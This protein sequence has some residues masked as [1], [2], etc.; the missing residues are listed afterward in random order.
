MVKLN[1][2]SYIAG[3]WIIPSS[4]V[5]QSKSP[6]TGKAL[7]T[8]NSCGLAEL[9]AAASAAQTAFAEYRVCSHIQISEFLNTI[10]EEIESL[11]DQLLETADAESGLGI[12]RMTGERARTCGQL[13]AFADIVAQGQWV[14]ASIDTAIPDRKPVPKPDLRRMMRPLGPVAVF[15]ASNFPFAY[16]SVGGD[17]ASALAAGNP[18][19][20]KGHPSHPATNELF[21][22][23][24]DAAI[25][26]CNMPRGV[27]SML[28]GATHELGGE[29]VKHPV[30]QAV[31]FTGSLGGGRAFMDIA[32]SRPTPIPV[33]AE[34]GSVNPIFVATDAMSTRGEA[35]GTTLAAS[36]AMGTGQF[37][38]SPGVVVTTGNADFNTA[39][40]KGLSETPRGL[41]LNDNIGNALVRAVKEI[42]ARSDV[43]W[44]NQVELSDSD[45]STPPNIVL[46]TSAQDFLVDKTLQEEIFGP[47]TMIVECDNEQ[48][49]LQVA[50]S[51]EGNLTAT[52]HATDKD[53]T[54]ANALLERLEQ[55]A[56]R[57]I[58]NGFPTGVEV[59]PSQQHGGPYPAS[60]A[61]STTSVGADAM[62][63]FARFVAYQGLPDAYLPSAL[64]NDNPLNLLRKVNGEL[65]QSKILPVY[66]GV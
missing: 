24:L 13:R 62:L 16:G 5:F 45:T 60:S 53:K 19:I 42:T 26:R 52:V 54:Q 18:V 48:Q 8:Y 1:Q 21:C 6:V 33:F 36:V 35:I 11:G 7:A 23:A 39:V 66:T 31:G 37:C 2:K 12:P 61:A 27:F 47:V 44:L 14:Q 25:T 28:Q 15:G 55:F 51:F 58:Y 34:M 3:S 22:H 59:C 65:T 10:A 40:A 29:L 64:K 20:V 30:V 41:L 56:G 9:E 57:V 43:K 50:D 63:R 17:T 49:M 38:T 46:K 4:E 32:A